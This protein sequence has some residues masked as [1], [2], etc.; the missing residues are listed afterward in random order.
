MELDESLHFIIA[1]PVWRTRRMRERQYL[2][3][4]NKRKMAKI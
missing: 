2:V 1:H 3:D 4:I